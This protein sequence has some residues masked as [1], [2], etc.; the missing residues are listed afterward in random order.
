MAVGFITWFVAIMYAPG[1]PGDLLGL[2]TGLV[3]MLIVTALTQELD[4]P[5]P[6]RNSDGEVVE[7]KDRL[8]TLP[9]FRRAEEKY[10]GTDP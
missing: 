4:P 5:E 10:S 3:A 2:L 7:F 8:G 1:F 6:L 9:L